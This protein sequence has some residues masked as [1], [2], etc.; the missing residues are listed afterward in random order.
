M[1]HRISPKVE[2]NCFSF[3]CKG[4]HKTEDLFACGLGEGV[5]ACYF[6]YKRNSAKFNTKVA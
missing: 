6:V 2:L 3:F 5:I 1:E 4:K